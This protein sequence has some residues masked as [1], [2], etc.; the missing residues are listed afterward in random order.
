[1]GEA[2]LVLE[3]GGPVVV[4]GGLLTRRLAAVSRLLLKANIAFPSLCKDNLIKVTL[5]QV[6]CLFFTVFFIFYF[7]YCI[8]SIAL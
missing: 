2:A 4:E 7:F 3:G 8:N 6:I 1:M 5:L